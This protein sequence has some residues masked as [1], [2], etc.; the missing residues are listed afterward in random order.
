MA[1]INFCRSL[2]VLVMAPFLTGVIS[3]IALP[4]M[5]LFGCSGDS[6]QILPRWWAKTITVLSGVSVEVSG[7]ENLEQGKPYIFAANHQSQFD[8]FVLY[9]Y[10]Q[11]NFR[12]LAKKELFK[13]P[14]FG[15]ALRLSGNIPVDR[16]KGREALK[17]L[18]EAAERIAQGTSV[19]IFPEGT[20]SPDG[21]LQRFKS[22]VMYLAIK[23]GVEVVPVAIIGTH[24]VLPKGKML[25]GKGNV[26]IVLGKPVKSSSYTMKQKEELADHLHDE[27]GRLLSGAVG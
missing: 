25:A 21:K 24:A 16:S 23:S 17:S 8:I 19:I 13:L 4:A 11:Y 1:F 5:F 20:R 7:F 9:G 10:L 26:K 2:L 18:G 22:G 12:W 3:L 6:I 15:P 14:L 27:V